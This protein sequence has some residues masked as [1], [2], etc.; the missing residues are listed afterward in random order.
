MSVP[1]LRAP[2]DIPDLRGRELETSRMVRRA[3]AG[4]LR[5]LGPIASEP[6]VLGGQSF[7]G[8][9]VVTNI[10]GT[11]PCLLCPTFDYKGYNLEH[12]I[13][14]TFIMHFSFVANAFDFT[15]NSLTYLTY[16]YN[17]FDLLELFPMPSCRL[18]H[19]PFSFSVNHLLF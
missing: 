9:G 8:V 15:L 7:Q 10:E 3:A 14:V 19:L 1:F 2:G 13:S 18:Q 6:Q 4:L 17:A 11:C 16:A 12:T 5:R